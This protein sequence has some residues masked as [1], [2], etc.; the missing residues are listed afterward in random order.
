V[1]IFLDTGVLVAFANPE[2][3]NDRAGVDIMRG[4]ADRRWGDTYT[5]DYVL[6]EA[7]T[8]TRR[9]TRRPERA[10]HV[11]RLILGSAE[12]GWTMGLLFV[13]PRVFLK[14]WALFARLSSRGLSFTDCTSICLVREPRLDAIASFDSGFDGLVA[15]VAG[16]QGPA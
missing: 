4:V 11:G 14:S 2:D 1:S 10:I 15:R 12:M 3:A 13:S 5:S 9:R 6:D 7:V 8:V 16:T